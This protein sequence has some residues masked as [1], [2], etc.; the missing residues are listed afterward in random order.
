MEPM[1]FYVCCFKTLQDGSR[2]GLEWDW[3]IGNH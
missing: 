2:K 3:N 1:N